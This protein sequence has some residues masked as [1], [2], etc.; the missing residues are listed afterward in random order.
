MRAEIGNTFLPIN[1]LVDAAQFAKGVGWAKRECS[2]KLDGAEVDVARSIRAGKFTMGD[3]AKMFRSRDFAPDELR[4]A[5][6]LGVTASRKLAEARRGRMD[7][8]D[9]R[10]AAFWEG[11]FVVA[12]AVV[13]WWTKSGEKLADEQEAAI[14]RLLALFPRVESDHGRYKPVEKG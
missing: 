13:D 5:R 10:D 6:K 4:I 2:K 9:K 3:V 12:M 11:V 1:R 7:W 14:D 8:R